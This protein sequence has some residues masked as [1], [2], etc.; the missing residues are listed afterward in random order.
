MRDGCYEQKRNV[1]DFCHREC[2]FTGKATVSCS[3][4]N[5]RCQMAKISAN[6]VMQEITLGEISSSKSFCPMIKHIPW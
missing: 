2:K 3:Q 1:I 6:N 5:C 4:T